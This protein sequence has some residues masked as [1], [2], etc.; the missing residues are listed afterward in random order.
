MKA[1]A[2]VILAALAVGVSPAYAA[3]KKATNFFAPAKPPAVGSTVGGFKVQPRPAP[4]SIWN[5]PKS[6]KK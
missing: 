3:P 1:I 5:F 6:K 2:L 4:K